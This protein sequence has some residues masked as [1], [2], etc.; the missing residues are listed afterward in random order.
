MS[1]QKCEHGLGSPHIPS[2][3]WNKQTVSPQTWLSKCYCRRYYIHRDDLK[4][5]YSIANNKQFIFEFQG[6]WEYGHLKLF[7]VQKNIV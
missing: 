5:Q 3:G 4:I 1:P 7:L 6:D 2:I